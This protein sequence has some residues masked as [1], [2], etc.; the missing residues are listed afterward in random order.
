MADIPETDLNSLLALRNRNP[1]ASVEAELSR[2]IQKARDLQLSCT[3]DL[4]QV[5][6]L[7]RA[8]NVDG[9]RD[10][11]QASS[12][13][14]ARRAAQASLDRLRDATAENAR[15]ESDK[16]QLASLSAARIEDLA[17]LSKTSTCPDV[18]AAA[19]S[20]WRS[21]LPSGQ[22]A[23]DAVQRALGWTGYL[24][25]AFDGEFGPKSQEA[26]AAWQSRNNVTGT[27]DYTSMEDVDLARLL[28]DAESQRQRYGYSVQRDRHTGLSLGLPTTL[29]STSGA[30]E[31]RPDGTRVSRFQAVSGSPQIVLLRGRGHVRQG[32][33]RPTL[34]LDPGLLKLDFDAGYR[35]TFEC[36][37]VK[38]ER[39]YGAFCLGQDE[40]R[41]LYVRYRV[42][43]NELIGFTFRIDQTEPHLRALMT[44]FSDDW[45][46]NNPMPW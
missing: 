4:R 28:R 37:W 42:V 23:A 19:Q 15:C 24:D 36:W 43:N 5:S 39:P 10:L 45:A 17:R 12:C 29:V 3:A 34:D 32:G 22:I 13:A 38:A 41:Q 31:N 33:G 11:M 21:W 18:A 14:E 27:Y 44:V 16:R 7:E 25:A 26:L 30:A 40:R 9:L 46:K 2:R 1:C 35:M 6:N 8:G 20:K